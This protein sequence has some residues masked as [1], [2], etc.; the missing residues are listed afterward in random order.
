M[1]NWFKKIFDRCPFS[2]SLP[3]PLFTFLFISPWLE[4][5]KHLD[6]P[7]TLCICFLYL[8][9]WTISK[10][11]VCLFVV[12]C[13]EVCEWKQS[14]LFW[15]LWATVS[16]FPDKINLLLLLLPWQK[17]DV[18]QLD[19]SLLLSSSL[20]LLLSSS[21]P[22]K[23]KDKVTSTKVKFWVVELSSIELYQFLCSELNNVS[24]R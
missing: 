12:V 4:F 17:P 1:L 3:C 14:V 15:I 13:S 23:R 10:M 22:V 18:E 24:W 19:C 9:L 11:G 16:S 7:D 8:T 20:P 2:S 5:A 6:L 21:P